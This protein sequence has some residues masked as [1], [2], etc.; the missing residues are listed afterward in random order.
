MVHRGSLAGSVFS[1][2]FHLP[3][4][5]VGFPHISDDE[6]SVNPVGVKPVI[7]NVD[8]DFFSQ[9][10]S[11]SNRG[12]NLFIASRRRSGYALCKGP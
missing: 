2:G 10:Q 7:E 1:H 3:Q 5:P 12:N 11:L 4:E 9:L 6:S 8:P